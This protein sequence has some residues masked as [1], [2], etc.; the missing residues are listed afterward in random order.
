VDLG[1]LN[2]SNPSLRVMPELAAGGGQGGLS[3]LLAT[4]LQLDLSSFEVGGAPLQPYVYGGLGLLVLTDPNPG[5][6]ER[7]AVLNL[8][9][10]VN[11]PVPGRS[12][13]P[14]LFL[15]HQGID[16]FDLNRL[17]IGIRF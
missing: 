11:F 4:N 7:E 16:L 6:A 10:G 8:G 2:A 12:G 3:V 15:E 14:R 5:R 13:G 1:P 17:L 9:Y